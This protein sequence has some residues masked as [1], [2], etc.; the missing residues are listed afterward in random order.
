VGRLATGAA[1][2]GALALAACML[3]P[4]AL[5]YQRY[6]ITGGSMTG[7]YDRGSIV[8]DRQVPVGD[9]RL[10]DVITYKPPPSAHVD[11]LVTH[12]IVAIRH[13]RRGRPVFR[14]K[15]DANPAPDPWHFTLSAASQP[16]VAFSIPYV[17]YGLAALSIRQVRMLAI[18]LPALLIAL[19]LLIGLWREAGAEARARAL[20]SHSSGGG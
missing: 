4:A 6:V 10:G 16:R 20:A 13:S 17:G 18:G 8:F 19:S 3:I 11:G 9:L 5:G 7:A 2:L 1:L 15:G 12:R 14:T